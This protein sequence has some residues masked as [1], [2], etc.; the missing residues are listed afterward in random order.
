MKFPIS[1]RSSKF[2]S[3]N[4]VPI[5]N[6]GKT[7]KIW[8]AFFELKLKTRFGARSHVFAGMGL[9]PES[10]RMRCF[11]EGIE[12][13][14]GL[15][16]WA[17]QTLPEVVPIDYSLADFFPYLPE[18]IQWLEKIR[19]KTQVASVRAQRLEDSTN[20]FVP[21]EAVFPW[22][23]SFS[24][25]CLPLP[26]TDGV[27][28]AAG[29]YNRKS[30]TIRRA[31]CEVLER[32]ALMLSWKVP[33]W[34]KVELE[35]TLLPSQIINEFYCQ[36]LKFRLI[37][38]GQYNGIRVVIT[39]LTDQHFRTTIGV[40]CGGNIEQDAEK[41]A[42]EALMLRGSALLMCNE[43]KK[44]NSAFVSS[45]DHVLWGWKN[46]EKVWQWYQP[47]KKCNQISRKNDPFLACQ[48][49]GLGSP[50]IVN[51]TPPDYEE[52]GYYICRV[53]V[54]YAFRK[55]YNHSFRYLGGKRLQDLGITQDKLNHLPHPIG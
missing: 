21:A 26:E 49:M 53:I 18:Q 41:S 31:L 11:M 15:S 55:E 37:D 22:W 23:K 19:G 44:I 24:D 48:N 36:K 25:D 17:M 14:A 5:F 32:D 30:E 47:N 45:E 33:S 4:D 7:H 43:C 29:F 9:D 40:A 8:G 16:L 12:R 52:L 2:N 28:F 50:L 27:G 51:T 3:I 20:H 39:L 46:G 54:P 1:I 10:A 35:S 6:E 13:S 42:L 38:I 34:E